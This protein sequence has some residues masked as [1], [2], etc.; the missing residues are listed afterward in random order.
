[1][2]LKETRMTDQ[3]KFKKQVLERLAQI[4]KDLLETKIVQRKI[5]RI[6][7]KEDRLDEEINLKSK[8]ERMRLNIK[9]PRFSG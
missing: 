4:E 5:L 6:L 9:P 8:R 1:M 2:G 3:A 7:E